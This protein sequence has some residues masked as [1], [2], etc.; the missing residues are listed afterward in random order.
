MNNQVL[1]DLNEVEDELLGV[2][3]TELISNTDLLVSTDLDDL[4]PT[5][6][7]ANVLMTLCTGRG[8]NLRIGE[9]ANSFVRKIPRFAGYLIAL[10][11]L[12]DVHTTSSELQ[13][14]SNVQK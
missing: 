10:Q 4:F 14:L 6:L 9:R 12:P 5:D 3:F 13:T 2:Q 8:E 1:G 7:T 11:S